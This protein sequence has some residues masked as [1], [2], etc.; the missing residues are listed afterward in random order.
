MRYLEIYEVIVLENS[1]LFSVKCCYTYFQKKINSFI[2]YTP[3]ALK[4]QKNWTFSQDYFFKRLLYIIPIIIVF[5]YLI[6]TY[7]TEEHLEIYSFC[8]FLVYTFMLIFRTEQKLKS[9]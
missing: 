8:V 2:R 1:T 3:T 5:D 4:N 7:I 6:Q 9:C